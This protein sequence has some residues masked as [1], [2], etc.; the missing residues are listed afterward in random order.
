MEFEI[1][2]FKDLSGNADQ[3]LNLKINLGILKRYIKNVLTDPDIK[4]KSSNIHGRLM[5]EGV[6]GETL[7][8]DIAQEL[9]NDCLLHF[10]Q[11]V[12]VEV[13]QALLAIL[14]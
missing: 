2:S 11:G 13:P 12:L 1:G 4:N 10:Q 7:L 5:K 6:P 3:F 8:V 9:H 14:D